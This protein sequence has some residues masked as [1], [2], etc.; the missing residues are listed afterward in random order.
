MGSDQTLPEAVEGE[1]ASARLFAAALLTGN[2]VAARGVLHAALGDGLGHIYERIVVPAL[3]EVGTLWYENR[4]TVADE[5]LASAVAQTA[6]ASLYPLIRWP[7]AGP[8]AVVGCA[9]PE[10]HTFG[11]RM[12]ADLLA[13]DGWQTTYMGGRISSLS[14]L[15]DLDLREVRLVAVSITLEV[16]MPSTR[17]LIQRVREQAPGAKVL[18]GGRAV[19]AQPDAAQLLGADAVVASLSAAVRLARAWR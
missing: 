14:G 2:Y 16:H 10:L 13:L 5:H 19:A 3:Q 9:D 17:A 7:A 15:E 12:L 11:A 6:V 8:R 1:G 18:A 4:I